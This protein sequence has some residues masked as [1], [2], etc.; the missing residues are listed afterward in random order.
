MPANESRQNRRGF[1]PCPTVR[2]V[3]WSSEHPIFSALVSLH[4]R[5]ARSLRFDGISLA[6]KDRIA[7]NRTDFSQTTKVPIGARELRGKKTLQAI[8][9][10][11]NP[12]GQAAQAD[13]VDIVVLHS[14]A[15]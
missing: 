12:G 8:P 10:N 1:R 2:P 11:C 3:S 4:F 14:P 15:G 13:N 5:V 9:G 7:T 6:V